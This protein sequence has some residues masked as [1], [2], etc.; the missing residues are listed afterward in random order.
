MPA[1]SLLASYRD[2]ASVDSARHHS[3]KLCKEMMHVSALF[4]VLF[5]GCSLARV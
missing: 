2:P 4:E 5:E 3:H 1:G